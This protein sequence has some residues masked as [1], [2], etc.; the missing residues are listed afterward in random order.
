MKHAVRFGDAIAKS[1]GQP[2]LADPR[3]SADQHDL[4]FT[5]AGLLPAAREQHAL[6]I[7]A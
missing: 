2:G 5:V 1:L 7:A 6:F 3:L 4:P